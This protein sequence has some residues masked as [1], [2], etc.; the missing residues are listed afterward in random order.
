M[1]TITESRNSEKENR[2]QNSGMPNGNE[3]RQRATATSSSRSEGSSRSPGEESSGPAEYT[4]DQVEAVK[5]YPPFET[6]AIVLKLW[7]SSASMVLGR[8]VDYV[9]LFLA[10]NEN[11]KASDWC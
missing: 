3:F 11:E 10:E 2:N 9:L 6:L 7:H 5:R 1:S 4:A 8:L